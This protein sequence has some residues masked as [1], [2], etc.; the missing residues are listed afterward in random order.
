M[1]PLISVTLR[2]ASYIKEVF[3]NPERIVYVGKN[4][5]GT[6][7]ALAGS[8]ELLRIKEEPQD[9]AFVINQNR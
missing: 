4:S 7:M 3:I 5:Y 2:E 9:I 1:M 6:V 8:D